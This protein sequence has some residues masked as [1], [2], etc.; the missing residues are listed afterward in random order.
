MRNL[1]TTVQYGYNHLFNRI[2]I[3]AKRYILVI[4]VQY[5]SDGY[6]C[7][8][9]NCLNSIN[10]NKIYNGRLM[11]VC[12]K[13]SIFGIVSSVADQDEAY[14]EFLTM[15]DNGHIDKVQDFESVIEQEGILC[16]TSKIKDLINNNNATANKLLENILYSKKDYIVDFRIIREP[17]PEIGS[18]FEFLPIDEEIIASLSKKNIKRLYKFQEESTRQILEGKDIVIVAPTASGKTEAFCI[19]I[20]HK[21]SQEAIHFSSLRPETKIKRRRVFAVFVYP[22]KALARDQFPKIK[23]IADPLGV[24]VGIFDGDTSKSDRDLITTRLIPEIFITNFDVTS[25]KNM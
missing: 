10:L 24:N 6:R 14:L 5:M 21:I 25:T 8:N 16:P 2:I 13:C 11:F 22:T 15:Y 20:V 1:D 12:S 23:Q 7:P 18:Q 9:C 17:E 19:P 4:L 3:F